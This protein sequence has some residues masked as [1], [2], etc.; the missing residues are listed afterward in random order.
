[1]PTKKDRAYVASVI[2]GAAVNIVV[3]LALIP[4]FGA[5]GAALGTLAAQISVCLSQTLA[6][7][8]ELPLGKWALEFVPGLVIGLAM[9]LVIRLSAVLLP[10]GVLGLVAEILIGAATFTVLSAAYYFGTKNPYL[11]QLL[12]GGSSK[13]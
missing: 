8:G 11:K 13:A 7:R 5:T 6:V 4:P 12:R 9:L 2:I 3:N 10:D 1:M